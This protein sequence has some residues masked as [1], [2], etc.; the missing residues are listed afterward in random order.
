M[1]MVMVVVV[2]QYI[3]KV[4]FVSVFIGNSRTAKHESQSL[5]NS[6]TL[7]KHDHGTPSLLRA[8]LLL[9]SPP[10][11]Y[12]PPSTGPACSRSP[13]AAGTW[14]L[15]SRSVPPSTSDGQRDRQTDRDA[16]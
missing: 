10:P 12:S 15:P 3:S 8:A 1:M 2:G 7:L 6:F 13:V 4:N 14:P 16:N 5:T 9:S 11:F